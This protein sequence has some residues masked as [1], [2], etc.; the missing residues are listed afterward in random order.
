MKEF[1][2][3]NDWFGRTGPF[4]DFLEYKIFYIIFAISVVLTIFF[5]VKKKNPKLT[6]L[7]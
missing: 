2:E 4:N 6:K 3:S 7:R 1:F 5:L